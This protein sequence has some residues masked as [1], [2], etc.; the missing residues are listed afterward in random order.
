MIRHAALTHV[1]R[2]RKSNEDNFLA[3]PGRLYACADGMGGHMAGEVASKI[4]IQALKDGLTKTPFDLGR[5]FKAAHTYIV[6]AIHEAPD[7]R[8]GKAFSGGM[9]TTLTAL[10]FNSTGNHAIVA[11]VGDSRC[12]LIRNGRG[13]QVTTDHH[14]GWGRLANCL[15]VSESSHVKTDIIPIEVRRG[16]VF[17]L[18]TDGLSNYCDTDRTAMLVKKHIARGL[19]QVAAELVQAALDDGGADN[20]TVIV[21]EVGR[22]RNS[23]DSV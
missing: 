19:D 16:D 9:G 11:H 20:I 10:S 14:S 6:R 21:V 3:I 7:H 23:E 17:V 1:G 18:C 15:G 13:M 8:Y 2:V 12:Y 5:T 22:L 4:A